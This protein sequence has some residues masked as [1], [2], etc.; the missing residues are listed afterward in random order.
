M[1]F[2]LY[3]L[4][5]AG[6]AGLLIMGSALIFEAGLPRTRRKH[7][8]WATAITVLLALV[9]LAPADMR[10]LWLAWAGLF[11]I[12]ACCGVLAS[13]VLVGLPA[14]AYAAS[15]NLGTAIRV[16]FGLLA[17]A[18]AIPLLMF[19]M[20]ELPELLISALGVDGGEFWRHAYFFRSGGSY[21][22]PLLTTA[23][24]FIGAAFGPVLAAF[25]VAYRERRHP[26]SGN[27][28]IWR[29]LTAE[30]H[31]ALSQLETPARS[32]VTYRL[33]LET[34]LPTH[35]KT[36]DDPIWRRLTPK[37]QDAARRCLPELPS[38]LA[39]PR[40]KARKRTKRRPPQ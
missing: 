35:W 5:V 28:P 34:G 38:S 32:G 33:D 37:E 10:S 6:I 17:L 24:V 23:G 18:L 36:D 13:V 7:L 1:F 26:T 40:A 2:F 30:E 14:L 25:A 4:V 3:T 8:L 16:V 20:V 29:R 15:R 9:I 31:D 22:I 39:M 19:F 27:A 11:F 12:G 21:N